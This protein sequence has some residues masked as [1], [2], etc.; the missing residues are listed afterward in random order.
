M[1][2]PRLTWLFALASFVSFTFLAAPVRAQSANA[3][4]QTFPEVS[5]LPERKEMPDALTMLDGQKVTTVEQWR[6]RREEMKRILEFYEL[7]HA[8][9]PPGNVTRRGPQSHVARRQS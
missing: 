2:I 3:S 5:D 9:P 4:P 8:P 7:G 6:Q 1:K